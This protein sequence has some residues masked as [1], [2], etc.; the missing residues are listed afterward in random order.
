MP[1]LNVIDRDN[2]LRII[3][4]LTERIDRLEANLQGVPINTVRIADAAITN[5]KIDTLT[6]DKA[7]GGTATLGGSANVNGVLTVLDASA[8]EKVRLDKDGILVNS[9]KLVIKN[10]SDTISIDAKGIVSTANFTKTDTANASLNQSFTSTSL[11]DVTGSSLSFSLTRSTTVLFLAQIHSYLIESVGNTGEG[12]VSLDIDGSEVAYIENHSGNINF[13]PSSAHY[14]GTLSSGSHTVKLRA[15]MQNK[16]GS[17]SYTVYGFVFSYII[18][19][20]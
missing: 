15:Q 11:A 3:A 1:A 10:D 12:R 16:T 9:G 20:T 8:V 14:V 5:A 13:K 17:P 19:G 6:W 4:R 7:Q 2:L 18:F